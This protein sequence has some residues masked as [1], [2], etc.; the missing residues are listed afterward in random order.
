MNFLDRKLGLLTN[1]NSFAVFLFFLNSKPCF[2]LTSCFWCEL[3]SYHYPYLTLLSGI[4]TQNLNSTRLFVCVWLWVYTNCMLFNVWVSTWTFSNRRI[5]N[6]WRGMVPIFD[7]CMYYWY[8]FTI[9]QNKSAWAKIGMSTL[10]LMISFT[11]YVYYRVRPLITKNNKA[12][13]SSHPLRQ[14]N[15]LNT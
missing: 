12:V 2:I 13:I 6:R 5:K 8:S 9:V 14:N 7:V 1:G 11:Y 15:I 3:S 4:N 10:T